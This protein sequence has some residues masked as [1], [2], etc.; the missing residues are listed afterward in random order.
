MQIIA[1]NLSVQN[2]DQ[3][4]FILFEFMLRGAQSTIIITII[5]LL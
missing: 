2:N 1:V 4:D 3:E 5:K